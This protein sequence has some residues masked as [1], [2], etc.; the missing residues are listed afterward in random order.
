VKAIG[1]VEAAVA[2]GKATSL[3]V[4]NA[5]SV[6]SQRMK[7]VAVAV[8]AAVVAG[9][10]VVVE[11]VMAVAVVEQIGTAPKAAVD[12]TTLDLVT[13]ASSVEQKRKAVAAAADMAMEVATGVEVMEVVAGVEV[14]ELTL[15][16]GIGIA[17]SATSTTSAVV[18][19]VSNVVPLKLKRLINVYSSGSLLKWSVV[20]RIKADYFK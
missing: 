18:T 20:W 17:Q 16:L 11:E 19:F 14:E 12:L 13:S 15:V 9:T 1:F 4:L 5:S 6:I 7:V 3:A 10:E 2:A 8:A